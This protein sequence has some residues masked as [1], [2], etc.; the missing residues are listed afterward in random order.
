MF[1]GKVTKWNPFGLKQERSLII[2]NERLYNFKKKKIRRAIKIDKLA[3][4]TKS[5]YPGN[6]Q[7]FVIHVDGD[8]DLRL[9]SEMRD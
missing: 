5:L 2:T 7:E 6:T 9:K 8:Y 1:S 4:V 3:G